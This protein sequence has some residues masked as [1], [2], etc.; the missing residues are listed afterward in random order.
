MCICIQRSPKLTLVVN[1]KCSTLQAHSFVYLYQMLVGL[2]SLYQL[3][4]SV[5][6]YVCVSLC[7]SSLVNV[8]LLPERESLSDVSWASPPVLS[9]FVYVSFYYCLQSSSLSSVADHRSS[10]AFG[11]VNASFYYVTS[12]PHVNV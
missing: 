5:L 7:L 10:P 3:I 12:T 11:T 6:V 1:S 4:L 8:K 2:L 9:V